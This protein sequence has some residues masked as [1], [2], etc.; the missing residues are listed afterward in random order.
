MDTFQIDFALDSFRPIFKGTYPINHVPFSYTQNPPFA[1][2]INTDSSSKGGEHW[3]ALFSSKKGTVE[4]FDTS[5]RKP[6]DHV[7]FNHFGNIVYSAKNIQSMCSNLC[8]DFC[9]LFIACRLSGMSFENFLN[10]FSNDLIENDRFVLY[11][12]HKFFN[13]LPRKFGREIF[14]KFCLQV[15]QMMK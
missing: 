9:I 5:G 1:M 2:V 10:L 14:D 7:N 13:I 4:Y 8:A 3:I 11:T 6:I 12:V 15:S